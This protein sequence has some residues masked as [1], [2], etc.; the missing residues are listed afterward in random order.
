M[1]PRDSNPQSQDPNKPAAAHPRRIRER[2]LS[3]FSLSFTRLDD[4]LYGNGGDG[5]CGGNV[6]IFP[7]GNGFT[8]HG[9]F[10]DDVA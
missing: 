7:R 5:G 8:I 9:Q 1:P 2:E 6:I 10:G 3:N 4:C